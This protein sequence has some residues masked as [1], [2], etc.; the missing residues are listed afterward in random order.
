VNGEASVV[1]IILLYKRFRAGLVRSWIAS[2]LRQELVR[3][4]QIVHLITQR[5]G[6]VIVYL[7]LRVE[8]RI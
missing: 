3:E 6:M 5:K 1:T 7:C 8:L 4:A 2:F